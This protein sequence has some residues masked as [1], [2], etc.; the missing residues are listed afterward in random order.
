MVFINV[1]LKYVK[2]S[3]IEIFFIK[4]F[5][6]IVLLLINIISD[7]YKEIFYNQKSYEII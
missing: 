3:K 1:K 5:F 6:Y 2:K 7:M 4:S